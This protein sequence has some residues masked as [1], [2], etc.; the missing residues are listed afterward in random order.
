MVALEL[1]SLPKP[2]DAQSSTNGSFAGS[3]GKAPA[4]ST[5]TWGHMRL[6][7]SGTKGLSRCSILVGRVRIITSLWRTGDDRTLPLLP[8]RMDK[9]E[10][11]ETVRKVPTGTKRGYTG[12]YRGTR[13]PYFVLQASDL[14]SSTPL[15]LSFQTVSPRTLVH[16]MRCGVTR[17]LV[18]RCVGG[19]SGP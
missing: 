5:W 2:H 10:P 3:C 17:F 7:N 4:S 12:R 14:A 11:R 19:D 15:Q 16:K 9:V 6:E 13:R 8:H 18:R 1:F